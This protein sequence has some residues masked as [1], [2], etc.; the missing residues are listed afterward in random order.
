LYYCQEKHVL[1]KSRET[2]PEREQFRSSSESSDNANVGCKI[3]EDPDKDDFSR[4]HLDR[5]ETLDLIS[6]YVEDI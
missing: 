6:R 3:K 5:E 4:Q 2:F 1:S